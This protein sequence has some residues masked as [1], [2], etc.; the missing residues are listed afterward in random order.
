MYLADYH[1]HSR[2]SMDCE[3]LLEREAEQAASLGLRELCTT[4]HWDLL[5][6]DGGQGQ[7]LDWTPVLEQYRRVSAR[8]PQGL[9]L[10][11]GIEAGGI[12]E[13]P[14]LAERVLAAAPV[15]FVIGSVHNLSSGAGGRDLCFLDYAGRENC[16]RVL[17]D[18]LDSLERTA[19]LPACYDVLG[20]VLYPLR[21][22]DGSPGAPA[23]LSDRWERLREVLSAAVEAGRGIEVNTCRGR[24]LEQWSPVLRLYRDCG[25]EIVTVG[26]D[27]HAARDIGRGVAQA[28]ELLKQAGFRYQAV[29]SRR[30][31]QFIRL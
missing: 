23:D 10:R 9:K 16:L 8:L 26:S 17:D 3:E 5:D 15:D 11:L 24:T 14:D 25:G 4:D 20:H 18:Y 6:E 29:Y 27:A 2:C 12:P 21:Y 7:T 1:T 31:P 22:M 19:R 28:Q 30:T 13:D